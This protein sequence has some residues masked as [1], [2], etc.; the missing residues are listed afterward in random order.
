MPLSVRSI[1]E[2]LPAARRPPLRSPV[3][4]S[5]A[6]AARRAVKLFEP[7]G[8]K[9]PFTSITRSVATGETTHNS[10]AVLSGNTP[11]LATLVLLDEQLQWMLAN[12]GLD[13][14]V[15]RCRTSAAHLYE[16]AGASSFASPFVSDP[17]QRSSV[18]GTIDLEGVDAHD[19]NVALRAN[20]IVDTDGYRKL[21]RNQIRV[22]MF[23][24]VE[25][26]DVARL[27]ACID[28]VVEALV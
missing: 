20:G 1:V 5:I 22:G 14:C 12:G 23:P 17:M 18:V 24:S 16:W 2:V 25:P 8:R 19:V 9:C 21:A 4:V 3:V 11:A 13:W 26:D 28:H 6:G 10:P 15:E 7:L 27:T